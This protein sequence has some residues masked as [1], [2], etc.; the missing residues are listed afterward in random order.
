MPI[1]VTMKQCVVGVVVVAALLAVFLAL[2]RPA[3]GAHSGLVAITLDLS[4][5]N[6]QVILATGRDVKGGQFCN[7]FGL[8]NG[9]GTIVMGQGKDSF[10]KAFWNFSPSPG[11][12]FTIDGI[13]PTRFAC[14]I[15][16]LTHIVY[17]VH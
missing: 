9:R 15:N 6:D 2:P 10:Q 7:G 11:T 4:T 16:D 3:G 5:D 13:Q 14:I 1:Q 8:T 12:Q 17:I